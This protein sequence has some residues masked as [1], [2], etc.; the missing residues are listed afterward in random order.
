MIA[1]I[2]GSSSQTDYCDLC[3]KVLKCSY[4]HFGKV[5]KSKRLLG[6]KLEGT[7]K[8]YPQYRRRCLELTEKNFNQIFDSFQPGNYDP[9][10]TCTEFQECHQ[11][12]TS[13]APIQIEANMT[14]TSE[15]PNSDS[16]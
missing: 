14:Q 9:I 8:R 10:R 6:Q 7:C 11:A 15:T 4:G 16:L 2:P 12:S 5:V 3:V 1:N 13:P